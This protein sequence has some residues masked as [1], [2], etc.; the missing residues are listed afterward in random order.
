M[1]LVELFTK[2]LSAKQK[3]Y[4]AIR[5]V[6]FQEG[7]IDTIANQFKYSPQT[8]RNLINKAVKGELIIFPD[9]KP[10]PK[11]RQTSTE[12]LDLIIGLRRQK[13]I[14]SYQI[15]DELKAKGILISVRTVERILSDTGFP[16]LRRRTFE[17]RGL[18]KKGT[19]IPQRSTM[20]NFDLLKPFQAECA[21]LPSSSRNFFLS[22]LYYRKSYN[23][24]CQ[25]MR[26]SRLQ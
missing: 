13:K 15:A 20:L 4:E 10:G 24:C 9:I 11:S 8:L 7:N 22:A 2:N 26:A 5:A 18:S 1:K 19:M 12:H 16:K 25:A 14:N 21:V 3:Q 6:A 23:R 17:E